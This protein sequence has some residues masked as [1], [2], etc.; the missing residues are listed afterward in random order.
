MFSEWAFVLF[1]MLCS[2]LFLR[3]N[4]WLFFQLRVSLRNYFTHG[5][6]LAVFLSDGISWMFDWTWIFSP[7][8]PPPTKR[9]TLDVAGGKA[10]YTGRCLYPEVGPGFIDLETW[11]H[12]LGLHHF[13]YYTN[14][15][16]PK[17]ESWLLFF[18]ILRQMTKLLSPGV[19]ALGLNEYWVMGLVCYLN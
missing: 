13:S 19:G 3:S 2:E 14:L 5:P 6:F 1:V 10:V 12:L 11:S 18:L 16:R 17:F 4:Q 9:M 7:L 15:N 8:P